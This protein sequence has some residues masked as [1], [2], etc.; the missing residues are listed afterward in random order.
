MGGVLLEEMVLDAIR[1]QT[2]QTMKGKPVSRTPSWYTGLRSDAGK[3][4]VPGTD[5]P[6]YTSSMY[7]VRQSI[8]NLR[9]VF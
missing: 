6:V 9:S 4:S 7:K 1:K 3:P 8:S 2:E 5:R